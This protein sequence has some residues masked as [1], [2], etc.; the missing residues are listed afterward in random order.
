VFSKVVEKIKYFIYFKRGY[1]LKKLY[2][3]ARTAKDPSFLLLPYF[4]L[5]QNYLDF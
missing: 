4:C 1:P 5:V 3:A 2:I